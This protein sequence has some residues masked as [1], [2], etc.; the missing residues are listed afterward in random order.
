M[1]IHSSRTI[2]GVVWTTILFSVSTAASNHHTLNG[3][4]TLVPAKSDYAGHSVIQTGVV[5][6]TDR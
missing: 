4:W 2:R 6:I 5:T 3:T 1:R